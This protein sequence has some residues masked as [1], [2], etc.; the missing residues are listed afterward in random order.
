VKKK[1]FFTLPL[2]FIS[3]ILAL[4]VINV[5]TRLLLNDPNVPSTLRE[6]FIA[7]DEALYYDEINLIRNAGN[8][9]IFRRSG[10]PESRWYE[11]IAG[12]FDPVDLDLGMTHMGLGMWIRNNWIWNSPSLANISQRFILAGITHPDEMSGIILR[13]YH[14]YLN[15]LPYGGI[16]IQP[17]AIIFYSVIVLLLASSVFL[18]IIGKRQSE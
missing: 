1:I 2:V 15:G 18:I 13:G 3:L 10:L 12:G 14:A 5:S 4:V 9:D 6:S 16:P 11:L 8:G 17:G 7:L